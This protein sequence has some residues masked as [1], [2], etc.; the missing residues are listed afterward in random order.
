MAISLLFF[1]YCQLFQIQD[2]EDG[3]P[4]S[5]LLLLQ[6]DFPSKDRRYNSSA[7]LEQGTQRQTKKSS[8]R[9]NH[10]C[11]SQER[12]I[13]FLTYFLNF[14]SLSLS[15]QDHSRE[16]FHVFNFYIFLPN[17]GN[18]QGKM[19][20]VERENHWKKSWKK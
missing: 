17:T 15:S 7:I 13:Y 4:L 11:K 16:I 18:F 10:T 9:M 14:F 5:K 19:A 8:F 2:H 1:S 3:P 20:R 6:V 12:I